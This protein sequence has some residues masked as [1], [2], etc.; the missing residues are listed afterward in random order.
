MKIS[1][2]ALCPFLGALFLTATAFADE[3]AFLGPKGTYS[4]EAAGKYVARA[5][6]DGA[7]ALT[8]ITG[9]A[10]SVGEGR[11]QFGLLPFDFRLCTW[12]GPRPS[13]KRPS[14]YRCT[15][16]WGLPAPGHYAIKS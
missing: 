5:H 14:S 4:D 16:N 2:R 9:I 10:Q 8:T 11:A 6:L 12:S 7:T 13:P 1:S 3:L 15:T